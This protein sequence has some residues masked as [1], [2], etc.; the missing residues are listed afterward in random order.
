MAQRVAVLL[1]GNTMESGPKPLPCVHLPRKRNAAST[2]V[3]N[4]CLEPGDC[5]V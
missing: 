3:A 5:P 2:A 4:T 1:R